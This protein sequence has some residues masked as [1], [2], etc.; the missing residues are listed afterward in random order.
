M[1]GDASEDTYDGL[2]LTGMIPRDRTPK[3]SADPFNYLTRCK[4]G[5]LFRD[6]L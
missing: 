6:V 5:E 4:T 1:N 3:G 2:T